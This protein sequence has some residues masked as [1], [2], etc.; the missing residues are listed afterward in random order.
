MPEVEKMPLLLKNAVVQGQGSRTIP[1]NQVSVPCVLPAGEEGGAQEAWIVERLRAGREEMHREASEWL[2]AHKEELLAIIEVEGQRRYEAAR[3][4]GYQDGWRLAHTEAEA[5]MQD[6]RQSYRLLEAD[7][8]TFVAGCQQ[9]I[10]QLVVTV[11][12][13]VLR[14]ELTVAAETLAQVI[15]KAS[16]ELVDRRQVMIFVHPSRLDDV[17][18]LLI[19]TPATLGMQPYLVRPDPSLH[20]ASFRAEDVLGT[21]TIDLPELLLQLE[22][23]LP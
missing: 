11:A 7:R 1:V 5:L 14:Q 2:A 8:K 16:G 20:V 13:H 18:T 12:E 10:S 21:V 17:Q 9:D 4:E 22:Q 23:L 6:V 15:A 19:A 3:N